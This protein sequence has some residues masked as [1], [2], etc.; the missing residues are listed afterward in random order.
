MNP[1]LFSIITPTLQCEGKIGSTAASVLNQEPGSWEYLVL[2]GGSTDG[3][4]DRLRAL[5]AALPS[6]PMRLFFEPDR[7]I[8]DAMNKGIGLATG[9]FVLFL[10]A[11]DRLRPGILG[12]LAAD[13]ARLEAADPD[14]HQQRMVYGDVWWEGR[15]AIHGG[16]FSPRRLCFD[17]IC[18]QAILYERRLFERL[19][20]FNLR[21]PLCADHA[22][23]IR[24]FGDQSVGKVY[25]AR[26]IADYEGIGGSSENLDLAFRKDWFGLIRECFG[27]PF[28]LRHWALLRVEW[29]LRQLARRF[30][31]RVRTRFASVPVAPRQ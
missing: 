8:Y 20:S 24:A 14:N 31:A 23:N 17:N 21:Y 22:L 2:D 5:A 11:G 27:L 1:P 18:Q 4:P 7:G 10:G 25:L 16:E 13:L 28:A 9:R 30:A 29:R 12:E 26:I 15:D 3:T 6:A 19:G